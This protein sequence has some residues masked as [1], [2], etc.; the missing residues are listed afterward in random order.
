MAFYHFLTLFVSL[1]QCTSKWHGKHFPFLHHWTS[2]CFV[3]PRCGNCPLVVQDFHCCS[4]FLYNYLPKWGSSA[5]PCNLLVHWP[6]CQ[7]NIMWAHSKISFRKV[8]HKLWRNG[9]LVLLGSNV[10]C[11]RLFASKMQI[12]FRP[13]LRYLFSCCSFLWVVKLCINGCRYISLSTPKS[14]CF[15]LSSSSFNLSFKCGKVLTALVTSLQK[16]SWDHFQPLI[17]RDTNLEVPALS[18]CVIWKQCNMP[19]CC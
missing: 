10:D 11:T 5:I 2:L 16:M 1:L 4:H 19:E 3:Q 14:S 8:M 12:G 15:V 9:L 6:G 17:S 18:P 7:P 13:A